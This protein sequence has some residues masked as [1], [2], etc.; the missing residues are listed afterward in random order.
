MMNREIAQERWELMLAGQIQPG[1]I[2]EDISMMHYYYGVPDAVKQL[3]RETLKKFL[4]F[5][6]DFLKEELTETTIAADT[7]PVDSEEVVDGLIDLIVVAVGTLDLYG[8]DF[9]KAWFEVLKAN[10]NKEVGV[11]EGRTNPY[12]LPDLIKPEGWEAPN[13]AENHGLIAGI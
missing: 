12:G 7:S 1:D 9:K 5:R 2:A 8:V 10:M 11:K 3:D 6:V 13:H 4:K